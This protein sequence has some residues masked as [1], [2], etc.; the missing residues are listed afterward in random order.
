MLFMTFINRTASLVNAITYT[1]VT[2]VSLAE[3]IRKDYRQ[4][5]CNDLVLQDDQRVVCRQAY[6]MNERITML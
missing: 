5:S 2:F 4:R 1:Y 6:V 3:N